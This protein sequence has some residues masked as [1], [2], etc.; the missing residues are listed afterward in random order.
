MMKG[1]R[2]DGSLSVADIAAQA[3]GYAQKTYPTV[4]FSIRSKKHPFASSISAE[5]KADSKIYRP[6]CEWSDAHRIS[7]LT[8]FGQYG[9]NKDDLNRMIGRFASK[10]MCDD[11]RAAIDGL[12]EFIDSYKRDDSDPAHDYSNCNFHFSGIDVPRVPYKQIL[13]DIKTAHSSKKVD[14][15]KQ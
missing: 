4:R 6:F 15:S 12:Y 13:E 3:R 2:Y 5:L 9:N 1:V 14:A 8:Y 11:A 10:E 7:M